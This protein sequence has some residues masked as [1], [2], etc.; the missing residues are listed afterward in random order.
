M[1]Y[2]FVN[3]VKFGPADWEELCMMRNTKA[4][5]DDTQIL[6]PDG[7]KCSFLVLRE[8]Q[9][10]SQA[11]ESVPKI[12][13]TPASKTKKPDFTVSESIISF[14]ANL[15]CIFFVIF[16]LVCFAMAFNCDTGFIGVIANV[17]LCA[18]GLG[19]LFAAIT[20]PFL[21]GILVSF[22]RALR[23]YLDE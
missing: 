11:P 20:I 14:L 9:T 21:T 8:R 6:L 10:K 4:I 12:D 17:I 2:Y 7:R 23:K 18:I 19:S 22:S 16:A 1:Y 5:N 13:S 15:F 3:K